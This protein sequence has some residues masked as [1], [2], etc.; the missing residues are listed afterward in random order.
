MNNSIVNTFIHKHVAS[1]YITYIY[2]N[3]FRYR[4]KVKIGPGFSGFSGF[5]QDKREEGRMEEGKVGRGGPGFSGFSGLDQD[6]RGEG[7]M[8]EGKSGRVKRWRGGRVEE[9]EEGKDGWVE[10]LSS[11]LS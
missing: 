4:C 6:K 1:K 10:G 11:I 3:I 5:D 8:E 2:C 7:R 9:V